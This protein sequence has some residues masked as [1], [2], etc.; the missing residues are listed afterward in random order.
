VTNNKPFD[1]TKPV[2]TRDGRKARIICTDRR[3]LFPI[4]ALVDSVKG[5]TQI[6]LSY[7]IKGEYAGS[8]SSSANLVNIVE[9]TS[10]F[11]NFYQTKFGEKAKGCKLYPTLK[12]A[13]EFKNPIYPVRVGV[14]EYIYEDGK[15]VNAIFHKGSFSE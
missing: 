13:V 4:V 12:E 11:E 10:H 5:D 6:C 14:L 9:R 1:P 8:L 2:Q 3:G 15:F 7:N